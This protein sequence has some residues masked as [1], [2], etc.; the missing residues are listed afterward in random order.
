MT[1]PLRVA[2]RGSA[3]ARRQTDLVVEALGVPAEVVVVQ[4]LGDRQT[5]AP[6]WQIGGQGVF[7]K[8]VQAAV[9]D[10]RADF[11][12]HSAKDLPSR[13]M[14]GLVIAAV[15]VRDDPRDALV[16]ASLDQLAPGARIGTGSVRRRA[17]LAWLRPDL[18][19]GGLRGN[20]DTRLAKAA[21]F[22]AVV[23]AAAA[24]ARLNRHDVA[25]QLLDPELVVPQVGQGA[26]AV[27]CRAD[28]E[29]VRKA[30][31]AIDHEPSHRRLTAERAFLAEVG[32]DCELPVG[33]YAAVRPD[34]GLTLTG[35]L[36]RL[37]GRVVLRH[38]AEGAEGDEPEALGRAVAR[39]LLDEAGGTA[40]L[41]Q[42]V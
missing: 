26:L 19:F 17:Q 14:E 28:D 23:I 36:A 25:S 15:P 27:E 9:L 18:T 29:R 39:H 13:E 42:L 24:L 20:V 32:G 35:I 41:G 3:L 16:G 12:V 38:T 7:V 11:A 31:A 22:D 4:T 40:L 2:T 34:G 8:E 37:D 6:I 33:A 21:S 10:G 1:S 5:D 30:L